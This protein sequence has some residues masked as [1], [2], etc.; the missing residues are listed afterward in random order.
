MHF[1]VY[2]KNC[3]RVLLYYS[4]CYKLVVSNIYRHTCIYTLKHNYMQA[5]KKSTDYNFS[6][7]M[8]SAA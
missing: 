7:E 1:I 2:Q 5:K 3:W 8:G 4:L 6:A